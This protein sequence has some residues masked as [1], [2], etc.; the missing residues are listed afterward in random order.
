MP[1]SRIVQKSV[2]GC[3]LLLLAVLAQ[4]AGPNAPRKSSKSKAPRAVAPVV[5]VDPVLEPLVLT[6]SD[7]ALIEQ[8]SLGSVP[9][10]LG[11]TVAL[12]AH[13]TLAGR[14]VLEH[15]K[16]RF[17]LVVMPTTTGAIRL[18][19]V[20]QGAVWLQLANKSMLMDQK[21]GRRL[22]DA[23]M[24]VA[25]T[26]VAEAME[27]T[28]GPGLLDPLPDVAQVAA[29]AEVMQPIPTKSASN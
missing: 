23:C 22:A 15:D 18:E 7:K 3:V 27:R 28:P 14:F 13:P 6:D 24:N 19:D 1:M 10:E 5:I 16:R 20:A 8:V 9:C 2:L 11:A 4:A 25:Q 21:N 29:P 12:T 26:Q 17:H